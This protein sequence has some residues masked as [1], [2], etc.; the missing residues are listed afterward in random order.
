MGHP[1][2]YVGEDECL[3]FMGD[4]NNINK[5]DGLIM[6]DILPPQNLY[7]PIL[8]VKMHGKLIFPLC[9]KCAE[10]QVQEDCYH[11]NETERTLT[12]TWVSEEIKTAV[13]FG[14]KIRKFF[15]IWQYKMT[16]YNSTTGESGLFQGYIDEFFKQKTLA[17]GFPSE[18]NNDQGAI[19]RYIRE[20]EQAE[21]IKLDKNEISANPGKRSVS[22]LCLN[23]LWGK[24]GQKEN[25]PKTEIVTEPQRF[26]ELLLSS[27]IIVIAYIPANDDTLYVSWCYRNEVSEISP[28]INVVIAGCT[29]AGARL[30]LNTYLQ[31]LGDRVLYYDTDSI[32]YVSRGDPNEYEPPI[33]T[34]LGDMTDELACYGSGSYITSFVSGGPKFYAYKVKK[35]DGSESCVCKVKGIRLNY[36]NSEKI[37]FESIRDLVTG[38]IPSI[39]LTFDSIRRTKF[40]NVVTQEESKICKP[41]YGKRRFVG[42]DKSYPY[43][44]KNI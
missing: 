1:K 38:E 4:I 22:K 17:S 2:L 33:G 9:R 16:Q 24:F 39:L 34:L 14:Y 26:L 11:E 3:D 18:C 19:D 44:Y 20:F 5:V 23:S 21:G 43:G 13:K 6:C 8:P 7:H 29:T 28:Y 12:G 36:S 27:E 35:S 25:M 15:E 37:N 10:D 40:H 32:I 41:V 31:P 42:L 30:K